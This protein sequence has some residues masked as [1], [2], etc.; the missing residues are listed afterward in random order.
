MS[1]SSPGDRL[2]R[3]SAV[4]AAGTLASRLTGL[5]RWVA[6]AYAMGAT[7]SR[8]ADAYQ[9][10][11]T[12][13]N[14]LY[15]LAL[16]GVLTSVLVPIFVDELA[17]HDREEGWRH[18]S[19]V[20]WTA[21]AMGFAASALLLAAA[22]LVIS[23]TAAG[24]SGHDRDLAITLLRLFSFQILFYAL[25]A[26]CGGVLNSRRHFA[27]PAF[28]PV[29]NNL[30]V[31]GVFVWFSAALSGPATTDISASMV[32]L[33]GLGTTV[34]VAAMALGNIPALPRV[35][36]RL[37]P[38]VD[39]RAPVL[40]RL[41][42]LSTW[43]VLYV[44]VN[45]IG[46]VV[47]QRLASNEQGAYAAWNYAFLFFQLPNGLFAVSVMT[48]LLPGLAERASR[49]DMAGFRSR[50][51]EGLRLSA[52]LVLPA[53]IALIAF[54]GPLISLFFEYGNFGAGDRD[55][56][57]SVLRMFSLGLVP[58]TL[59]M[60]TLRSFYAL[61]D[62]RTPFLVNAAATAAAIP[63]YVWFDS[64]WGVQGMALAYSLSYLFAAVLG[65]WALRR[66]LGS[67]T[68]GHDR[69]VV[70]RVLL[71]CVPFGAVCFAAVLLAQGSSPIMWE[72]EVFLGSAVGVVVYLVAA[73]ALRVD[74]V[75][76][77]RNLLRRKSGRAAPPEDTEPT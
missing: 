11:N 18:I 10:A 61:K 29:L 47:I 6:A 30:V 17:K 74:E 75:R 19:N 39:L 49:G 77:L 60:L 67:V 25:N 44:V 72:A 37:R 34:G 62:T 14:Q 38:H 23:L 26:L 45:Q 54:S 59:F 66:R 27:V 28:T 65:W 4:L 55:L 48:A 41:V 35:G 5:L 56:V 3:S 51:G 21:L 24:L 57:A 46:L 50:F 69:R 52:F 42:R 73:R 32:W 15:E 64:L 40:R 76:H 36:A 8:L 63:L 22:P 58:F 9:F 43:T 2:V 12:A 33:L 20:F 71:A 53:S 31:I 1:Q 16:G 70:G 68:S 13:P 7:A